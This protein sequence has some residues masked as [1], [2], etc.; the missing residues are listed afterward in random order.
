MDRI[1]DYD[2]NMKLII[3]L[4]EPISRA[5]SQ[6]NMILQKR[7][8]KTLNDVSEEQIFNSVISE[9]NIKLNELKSNGAYYVIRGFYD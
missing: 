1:Y 4:R 6:Y 7:E 5:F 2:K 3:I 9:E 8:K